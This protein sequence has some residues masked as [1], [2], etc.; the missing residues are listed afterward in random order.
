MQVVTCLPYCFISWTVDQPLS[1]AAQKSQKRNIPP[2]PKT[3]IYNWKGEKGSEQKNLQTQAVQGVAQK[4]WLAT[5]TI[6]IWY[7]PEILAFFF[8]GIILRSP[9]I[10]LVKRRIIPTPEWSGDFRKK[11]PLLLATFWGDPPGWDC[12]ATGRFLKWKPIHRVGAGQLFGMRN[13][14][15]SNEVPKTVP[16]PK[17]LGREWNFD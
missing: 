1:F 3:N 16:S 14:L 17:Q 8:H 4:T 11:T 9:A 15:K 6:G 13:L 10:D 2:P 12:H 5:S 7:N